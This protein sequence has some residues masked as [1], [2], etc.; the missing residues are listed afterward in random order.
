MTNVLLFFILLVLLANLQ[1]AYQQQRI[2]AEYLDS[3][4][5]MIG[6]MLRELIDTVKGEDGKE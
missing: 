5:D 3:L 2:T 4:A 1:A 6:D